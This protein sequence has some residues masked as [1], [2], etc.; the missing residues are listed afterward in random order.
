MLPKKHHNVWKLTLHQLPVPE[1]QNK[2]F[3]LCEAMTKGKLRSDYELITDTPHLIHVNGLVQERCNSSALVMELHLSCTKPL[4]CRHAW[5]GI[6]Y[7]FVTGTLAVKVY[8]SQ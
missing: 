5:S 1:T 7:I 8:D 4:M 3:P 2:Y 6:N